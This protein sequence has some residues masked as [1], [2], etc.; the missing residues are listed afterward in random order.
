MFWLELHQRPNNAPTTPRGRSTPLRPADYIGGEG[1]GRYG[2]QA[3]SN[4]RQT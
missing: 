1:V 4:H 3:P 2:K